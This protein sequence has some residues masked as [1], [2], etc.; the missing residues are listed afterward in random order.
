MRADEGTRTS[1]TAS[2]AAMNFVKQFGAAF[3]A[4][5]DAQYSEDHR[6]HHLAALVDDAIDT[7]VWL[8]RQPDNYKFSWNMLSYNGRTSSAITIARETV[9]V[10]EVS[11]MTHEGVLLAGRGQTIVQ[12][13]VKGF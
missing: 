10:P 12:A 3:S 5:S 13:V 8:F 9:V 6:N 11:K 7:G 2:N 4:W 1:R